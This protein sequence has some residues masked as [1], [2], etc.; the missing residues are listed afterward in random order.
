MIEKRIENGSVVFVET[1]TNVVETVI[2]IEDI[3]NDI[4]MRQQS[5]D[6]EQSTIDKLKEKKDFLLAL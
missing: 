4:A 6:L 3:D 5:I 1:S 2:K